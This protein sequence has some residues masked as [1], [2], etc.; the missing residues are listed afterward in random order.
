[1][2]RTYRLRDVQDALKL[3]SELIF[4]NFS[5]CFHEFLKK[6]IEKYI[7]VINGKKPI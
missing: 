1:M 4:F 6:K 3:W 2:R 7:L 5:S